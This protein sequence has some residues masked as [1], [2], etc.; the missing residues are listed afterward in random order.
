MISGFLGTLITLE[1]AVALKQKLIGSTQFW[2]PSKV[3]QAFLN[4]LEHF[5][6]GLSLDTCQTFEVCVL[7]LFDRFVSHVPIMAHLCKRSNQSNF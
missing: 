4:H 3:M 7:S 6:K 1:R 5:G 2:R